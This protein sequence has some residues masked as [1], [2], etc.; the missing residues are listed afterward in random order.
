MANLSRGVEEPAHNSLSGAGFTRLKERDAHGGAVVCRKRRCHLQH[1]GLECERIAADLFREILEIGVEIAP[2]RA[3][4][5]FWADLL[6]QVG[7]EVLEVRAR[8]EFGVC[9]LHQDHHEQDGLDQHGCP[10]LQQ[11]KP[12]S[13]SQLTWAFRSQVHD[14]G[15]MGAS[16]GGYSGSKV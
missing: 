10:R 3:S 16:F 13:I 15:I 7:H 9:K 8:I 6:E 4:S 12:D 11:G 14:Y 2:A 5:S 1:L